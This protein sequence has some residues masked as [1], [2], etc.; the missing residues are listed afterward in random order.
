MADKYDAVIRKAET[1]WAGMT[2][3]EKEDFEKVC[4]ETSS[5]GALARRVRDGK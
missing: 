2:A 3:N 4:R 1:N 5:R